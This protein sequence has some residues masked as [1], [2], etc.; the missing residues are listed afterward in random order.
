[1]SRYEADVYVIVWPS[2]NICVTNDHGYVPLVV[3]ISRSFPHSWLI[4]GFVIRLTRQVH[5]VVC[6]SL[7]YGFWLP[8]WY[9]L[10]MTK[11]VEKWFRMTVIY[12]IATCNSPIS[13]LLHFIALS[14]NRH[15]WGRFGA[16][17][18]DSTHHF[19]RH[20]CTKSGSLRF[21]QFSGCWLILSVY[22][23]IQEQNR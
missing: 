16:L 10:K 1:M 19:F 11:S 3:K 23:K 22:I 5:C 7:I 8:L 2:W 9:F 12:R 15:E 21:S 14:W 6:S 17:K 13:I 20:A 4:T 18:S